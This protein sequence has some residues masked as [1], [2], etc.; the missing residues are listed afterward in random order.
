MPNLTF[1]PED[2][3]SPLDSKDTDKLQTLTDFMKNN[4]STYTP[5]FISLIY[6]YYN[7]N[8]PSYKNSVHKLCNEMISAP[9]SSSESN[10]IL[11]IKFH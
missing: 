7:Y 10:L 9:S 3:K 2:T 11:P 6:S 5:H 8:H 4:T 1:A